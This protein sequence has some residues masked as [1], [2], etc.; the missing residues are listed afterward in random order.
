[1]LNFEL[2]FYFG[3]MQKLSQMSRLLL[4]YEKLEIKK[5]YIIFIYIKEILTHMEEYPTHMEN[6]GS[7]NK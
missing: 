2:T 7:T 3:K 1:M 5:A 6:I 4:M